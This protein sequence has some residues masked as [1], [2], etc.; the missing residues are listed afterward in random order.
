MKGRNI[1]AST[2][3]K[4]LHIEHSF[5][6]Q[7]VL[8]RDWKCRPP[9]RGYTAD[10]YTLC[11]SFVD[12]NVCHY[13]T[14]C[15]EAHGP[16][17]LAE[18]KQRFEYRRMRLQKAREKEL[19][20]KS[21]TEALLEKWVSAP[22]PEKVLREKLPEVEES[23][24]NELVTTI[25][26]KVSRRE[27]T[28]TL[29]TSRPLR[30]VALLQDAHR[31]HF[32]LK[33]ILLGETK[34]KRGGIDVGVTN[35]Q[36][37]V[38]PKPEETASLGQLV[39]HKVKVGFSTDIY[40]TFRQSVV[41][42][43]AMEPVLV[44]H[45]CVDVIPVSD[46]DKITEIK[47]DLVLSS[48]LRWD[49]S[50]AVILPFEQSQPA[51]M[52]P[53]AY[54]ADAK[55][56]KEITELYPCPK[57]ATFTLTQSTITEK[58]LTKNN[59]RN[60]MHEL[61]YVEEIARYEHVARFNLTTKLKITANYLLTPCGM[62]TSTAKYS[63]CGE[64]FALM[65]LS[66]DISEDTSAGRLILNN[67]S[68]IFFSPVPEDGIETDKRK[69]FEA[70]IE[71]K[72]KNAI[73]LKLSMKTVNELKLK[74]DH[75]FSA[76]IQFQLNRLSY[77][78][79]HRA[80][81]KI[82]DFRL[83]FPETMLPPAIPWTPKKQW[84]ESLD[85]KLNLKQKEAVLAI[86]SPVTVPLPP[87][88]LIGPFGTGKTFTLAQAIKQLI[89]QPDARILIC[90][91]SNSA[92]D[93]YII[94][95]LHQWVESGVEE[96]R[97]LRVYYHKRWV[98]TVDTIVQ[99]YCLIETNGNVRNF[100][101]PT[102]EDIRKHRIV[103]VTLSISME[104]ASLDLPKG[105]FTHIL[106]DEAAQAMECEA[107]MP[108]AL[109]SE[110]TKIVLAGDHMQMSPELFS[111][112]AK[113]RKLHISL[114]E[115]LYD[116]YTADFPCKILLCENYRAHEAII[117]FTSELFYDQKLISSGKQPKHDKF[118]PLTFFT[119]RGEDVQDRN[120]TAFYNNSEVY[121]IVERVVE[122]KKKWPNSWGKI[123][124]QSIGI[125]TP[126]ADQVFRIR[127]E[128]RKRRMGGIRVERVLNVQGK[129]FRAVFL[130]TVRTR[131][132]C[133][134]D[135][136]SSQ[137][138]V[139]YG[140]LSN[141]KLL[142]TAITRA[143]S[144]V[145]VVGD[146]VALCSIGRCRKVWE[147]FIEICNQNKSLFGITWSML[148]SQLDGVELKKTY[149]L[150]PLAPEFIPRAL[151]HEAYLREQSTTF[152]HLQHHH[153]STFNSSHPSYNSGSGGGTS[154]SGMN[155]SFNAHP[156]FNNVPHHSSQITNYMGPSGHSQ[157]P[158][159]VNPI[160]PLGNIPHQSYPHLGQQ[161]PPAQQQQQHPTSGPGGPMPINPQIRNQHQLSSP[162]PVMH[163]PNS[164]QGS[165][166]QYANPF[167]Y[168]QQQQQQQQQSQQPP[169]NNPQSGM[170]RGP[171]LPTHA[172]LPPPV[173]PTASQHPLPSNPA[174][175]VPPTS[176]LWGSVPANVNPTLTGTS[177]WQMTK[178]Q[179][180]RNPPPL[181]QTQLNMP[182]PRPPIHHP[183]PQMRS[184]GSNPQMMMT[185]AA[186]YMHNSNTKQAP[187][188]PYMMQ[189]QQQGRGMMP[190]MSP[191][192]P[193]A[194]NEIGNPL[195]SYRQS[196]HLSGMHQYAQNPRGGDHK[197]VQ[198]LQNVHFPERVLHSSVSMAGNQQIQQ[199]NYSNA[200]NVVDPLTAILPPNMS[201]YDIAMES[202][203]NQ[204]KWFFKLVETQGLETA[205]KFAEL[206][207]QVSN[208]AL[209]PNLPNL[210][211]SATAN[212]QMTR[213][214]ST[215]TGGQGNTMT[216]LNS[217]VDLAFD[218]LM[219]GSSIT[220]PLLRD[221][222]GFSMGREGSEAGSSIFNNSGSNSSGIFPMSSNASSVA[223]DTVSN[224]L[225]D[226][227]FGLND[228]G[229]TSNSSGQQGSGGGGS[230]SVPLYRRQ[231]G[232]SYSTSSNSSGNSGSMSKMDNMMYSRNAGDFQNLLNENAFLGGGAGS[233]QKM[234]PGMA[235][236]VANQHSSS[237]ATYASVLT[238]SGG[239]GNQ[240]QQQMSGQNPMQLHG[241]YGGGGGPDKNALSS[242]RDMGQAS[243]GFYN[244]FH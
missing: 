174:Q 165:S 159:H 191:A 199:N 77:C 7:L 193:M 2:L 189:Q 156:P 130:S 182:T 126:Y 151:Q 69:V 78:E 169:H 10:T 53:P 116:H 162:F 41:F 89:I 118:Y 128:L 142:N 52:N 28:F 226:S 71:D 43:F 98:A 102:L 197:D 222:F 167:Y 231:A 180:I 4:Y 133:T 25:S 83:I 33:Q 37:W 115:R 172:P 16:D 11:E 90:T 188:S 75:E 3:K 32:T 106:L 15:V 134:N 22:S 220:Q 121:E 68:S 114:L 45:M 179:P 140:F 54:V 39:E 17:E 155:P 1:L 131:R 204:L 170:L 168:Y 119:T 206:L 228:F 239:A 67:C 214:G 219:N 113:E 154:S 100:K 223:K 194:P 61:L 147:R 120:S 55:Y 49:E 178:Q 176:N 200:G 208:A 173:P 82:A 145:A 81:D 35:E 72:G 30:A 94:D 192:Y 108:L 86:T 76:D 125:M 110:T 195:D 146:P 91:H 203:E 212:P 42:D 62:A 105:Y 241:N 44:Q 161:Y 202:K 13:G 60:R 229:N 29:K 221:L 88:L 216:G 215:G 95:Y 139:D 59:Y 20:G 48:C 175:T 238:Q 51:H 99:K 230:G 138:E 213:A 9:P 47:K 135:A 38:S 117:K 87:I 27:W 236:N 148:R 127:S 136:N 244:Y 12:N 232:Q 196:N 80:I 158:A 186:A 233:Q 58:R 21:Y 124:D 36:E 190:P 96:A 237:T 19:Y 66:K 164:G 143:Q 74:S 34:G 5:N 234:Y 209:N 210:V 141:S 201:L 101:R 129:Q 242:F 144:L 181:S 217:Q 149:V 63:N 240:Q 57:A 132:T 112:F 184:P 183:M 50:N 137:A 97:P 171:P 211:N 150:N 153:P 157:P 18:W 79:W 109:A 24:S 84:S 23:C 8:G 64:L 207:R 31:N 152:N 185:A 205:N 225:F 73:Y 14:Q 103:V 56:E 93:L 46:A 104:L 227:S 163:H 6:L 218:Y 235:G 177:A 85:P 40:G 26:S 198:F 70:L 224:A 187:T 243:N 65:Q 160:M 123:N 92:A 111:D 107:I 122:L 166:G